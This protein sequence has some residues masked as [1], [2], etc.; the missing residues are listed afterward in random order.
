M[1]RALKQREASQ[2]AECRNSA[3]DGAAPLAPLRSFRFPAAPLFDAQLFLDLLQRD[4][5]RL[6]NHCL[7]PNQ[8]ENHHA[9][10]KRE[11][12]TGRERGHHLRE[13]RCR[14]EEHTSELQ[15]RQYL[16]CRLL[17]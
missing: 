4:S 6:W 11:N 2:T 3:E 14:S 10:K 8:L 9:G 5:L 16:V 13:E 15:S 7:H 17:L 12:G 1:E